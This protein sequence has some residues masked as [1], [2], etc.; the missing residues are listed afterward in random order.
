MRRLAGIS[1]RIRERKRGLGRGRGDK[2]SSLFLGGEGR[3]EEERDVGSCV[4]VG[5]EWSKDGGWKGSLKGLKRE[6]RRRG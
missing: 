3:G 2:S 4:G 5:E 1:V 6:H